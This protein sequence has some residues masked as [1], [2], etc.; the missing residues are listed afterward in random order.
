MH[1]RCYPELL[2]EEIRQSA[3][4]HNHS[5][6]FSAISN[7]QFA[8][9]TAADF[10]PLAIGNSPQPQLRISRMARTNRRAASS[11][12]A[13]EGGARSLAHGASRGNKVGETAQPRRGVRVTPRGTVQGACHVPEDSD[14]GEPQLN[15]HPATRYQLP[16]HLDLPV[17]RRHSCCVALSSLC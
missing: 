1:F 14:S 10:R 12:A 17:F 4:R 8:K 16:K 13:A 15:F 7:W 11:R 3:V 6:G 5:R 2:G 9:T